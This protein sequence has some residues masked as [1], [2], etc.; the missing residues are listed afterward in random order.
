M[1][2]HI[3]NVHNFRSLA[4]IRNQKHYK[5]NTLKKYR[6]TTMSASSSNNN[7]TRI[8]SSLACGAVFVCVYN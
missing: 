6:L 2:I 1:Y 5:K 7:T 4:V 8:G 3:Y